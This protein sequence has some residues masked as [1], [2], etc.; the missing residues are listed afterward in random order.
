MGQVS[1]S[2][3]AH[4]AKAHI[5]PA[6]VGR[7]PVTIRRP[8]VPG[9]V[10]PAAATVDTPGAGARAC[11]FS[12]SFFQNICFYNTIELCIIPEIPK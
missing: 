9:V 5:V 7:V 11:L 2:Y 12:V 4:E 8:A 1:L 6:V 3:C 10:V